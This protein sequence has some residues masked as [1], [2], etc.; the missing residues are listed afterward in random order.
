MN[1]RN[2]KGALPDGWASAP[3]GR[4]ADC[5]LGKMLDQAKNRGDP[6]PYLRNVNVQWGWIDVDDI[7]EM[8]ITADEEEQYAV[9]P[10]DLLVCEGGEP[11][12]CAVWYDGREM[13][14][15]KALHRV[16]PRG[17]TSPEY[18]RWWLQDAA[19]TGRLDGLFTGS[20]IKHL[21]GRQLARVDVALPPIAEQRRIASRLDEIEERRAS[22]ATRL[23]SARKIVERFRS[24]VLAAACSGRLTT[25][26][27]ED[28]PDINSEE[29]LAQLAEIGRPSTQ[30]RKS[31]ENGHGLTSVAQLALLPATWSLLRLGDIVDVGT[32]ATPLRKNGAYYDHGTIPWVTS[33]AVN[34]GTITTPTELI[35]PLALAETNVKVFPVRT[36]LVA[37]YGEGQTRGRVAELAI[38]AGTNQALAAV[39]FSEETAALQPFAR[40]FFEDSYQRVR[41][42]SIGGVQPNLNLGMIK[43]TLI[44]LPPLDEQHEI[45]QRTGFAQGAAD[46]LIAQIDGTAAT[47]DRVSKA[48]LAKAFCGQLV[49]TEAA[50]AAEAGHDFESAEALLARIG[51]EAP[52]NS[53]RR[54]RGKR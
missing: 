51:A 8:R 52:T 12:R 41:A 27:R 26:W 37:M 6:R 23:Q 18:L 28:H 31:A 36:L 53:T 16:R 17:G 47:L 1:E 22:T 40:L 44:P 35:T 38:E 5:R 15:Q 21:P 24:A 43:D 11:G 46:R 14:L 32:G 13:Y 42:L 50:L 25:D 20:T 29:L 4:I 39:L 19:S 7:K 30:R 33:G 9:M 2:E 34:A 48:S 45:V 49:P 10:R 3:L 54:G